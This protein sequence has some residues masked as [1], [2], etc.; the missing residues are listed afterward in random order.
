[1]SSLLDALV[2]FIVVVVRLEYEVVRKGKVDS[3]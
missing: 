1:M 2:R 3:T